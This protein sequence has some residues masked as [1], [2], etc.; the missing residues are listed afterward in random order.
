MGDRGLKDAK[1][2]TLSLS[3]AQNQLEASIAHAETASGV[4]SD[5]GVTIK[6]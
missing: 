3:R 2:I 4:I 6:V 5:D 1:S